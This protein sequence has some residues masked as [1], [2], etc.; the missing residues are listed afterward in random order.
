MIAVN[1][2]GGCPHP[3]TGQVC[4]HCNQR[5]IHTNRATPERNMLY[6]PGCNTRRLL[7]YQGLINLYAPHPE[8]PGCTVSNNM[9]G[10]NRYTCLT[11]TLQFLSNCPQRIAVQPQTNRL[12]PSIRQQGTD[13]WAGSVSDYQF[14]REKYFGRGIKDLNLRHLSFGKSTRI[15]NGFFIV[16]IH[17]EHFR[18]GK[19]VEGIRIP[20][21]LQLRFNAGRGCS[22]I[23]SPQ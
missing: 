13:L 3:G 23:P 11:P 5:R 17:R 7:P 22:S 1:H 20:T 8:T 9:Q 19:T 21:A 12:A 16:L 18:L 4:Q 6:L 10:T 15:R 14:L 2:R